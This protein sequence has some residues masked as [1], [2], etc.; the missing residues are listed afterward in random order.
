[1]STEGS[2]LRFEEF[3]RA[4]QAS[5]EAGRRLL[6]GSDGTTEPQDR[7]RR[8]PPQV[9]AIARRVQAELLREIESECPRV[10]G[11][12]GPSAAGVQPG[13][14]FSPDDFVW[15]TLGR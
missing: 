4:Y 3:G 6:C 14:A 13:R 9:L 10:K 2:G 1:M 12:L 8:L 15:R 11:H 7:L 5:V